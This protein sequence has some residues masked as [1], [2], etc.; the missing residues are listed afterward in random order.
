MD[1]WGY[2]PYLSCMGVVAPEMEILKSFRVSK[3][4]GGSKFSCN[5]CNSCD[6]FRECIYS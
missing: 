1:N 4:G 6:C 5:Y 3:V 2:K